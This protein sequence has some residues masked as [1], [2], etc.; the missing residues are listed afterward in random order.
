MAFAPLATAQAQTL[1]QID[2][3]KDFVEAG[4]DRP[5]TQLPV[6]YAISYQGVTHNLTLGQGPWS[7]CEII[8]ASIIA[9]ADAVRTL[10]ERIA[11]LNA[12]IR[13]L[14]RSIDEAPR[15]AEPATVTETVEI[16]VAYT[17]RWIVALVFILLVMLIALA[18]LMIING[19][20]DH[21]NHLT[22]LEELGRQQRR[23]ETLAKDLNWEKQRTD[24]LKEK[25]KRSL[26][27][28]AQAEQ[29]AAGAK[30][31][32]DLKEA[33]LKDARHKL[34]RVTWM[35]GLG[36]VQVHIDP[37]FLKQKGVPAHERAI[38][39][40]LLPAE[41]EIRSDHLTKVQC[42]LPWEDRPRK[43]VPFNIA[44]SLLGGRGLAYI[45]EILGLELDLDVLTRK[46]VG[47]ADP[48]EIFSQPLPKAETLLSR[49]NRSVGSDEPEAANDAA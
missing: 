39:I 46:G 19:R 28:Q 7:A 14:E 6:G 16:P 33:Q 22:T 30:E 43:Y 26:L 32:G 37:K 20:K 1:T 48:L 2:A 24:S 8:Q 45:Q 9:R 47:K 11:D 44:K 27:L 41:D 35:Y 13:D 38:D 25:I 17:P 42:E 5:A 31:R 15:P 3:C 23:N 49:A 36:K 21:K 29:D 10:Q 18:L 12:Q 34:A 4:L 40:P